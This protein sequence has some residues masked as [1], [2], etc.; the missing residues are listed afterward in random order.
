VRAVLAARA[1]VPP[2]HAMPRAFAA[3]A[4]TGLIALLVARRRGQRPPMSPASAP[5]AACA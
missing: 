4:A 3:V 1:L 2:D 5:L